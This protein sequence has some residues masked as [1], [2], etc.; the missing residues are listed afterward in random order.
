M[1]AKIRPAPWRRRPSALLGSSRPRHSIRSLR[2]LRRAESV[3]LGLQGGRVVGDRPGPRPR[4]A[5]AA[6][7]VLHGAGGDAQAGGGVLQPAPLLGDEPGGG[8]LEVERIRARRA[9]RL[10]FFLGPTILKV[11]RL[12]RPL[13]VGKVTSGPGPRRRANPGVRL[14]F[15]SV[16]LRA[17]RG[18]VAGPSGRP[19]TGPVRGL[20]EREPAISRAKR[21]Q[22]PARNEP[23]LPRETN[24]ILGAERTR[25][26]APSEPERPPLVRRGAAPCGTGPGD[27]RHRT[28]RD[29]I[30]KDHPSSS[31]FRALAFSQSAAGFGAAPAPVGS[32]CREGGPGTGP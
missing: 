14:P 22:S 31:R 2:V 9:M 4:H 23:N 27:A 20:P 26:P 3:V 12:E 29:R 6:D 5:E 10:I 21:T 24:P 8:D 7:P 13:F 11:G 17:A 19:A 16:R 30:D 28:A 32:W 25:G 18:R 1:K 15:A